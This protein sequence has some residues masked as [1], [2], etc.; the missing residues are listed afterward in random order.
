MRFGNRVLLIGVG[1]AVVY[2]FVEAFVDALVGEGSV[3]ERLLPRDTN[4][5]WMRL[6]TVVL[7]LGFAFYVRRTVHWRAQTAERLR[8]LE[9]AVQNA[10]DLVLITNARIDPPGPEIVYVNR[11]FCEQ[12]GYTTDELLGRTPRILQGLHSDRRVLDQIRNTLEREEDFL[13]GVTNYRKDGSE[14]QMEWRISPVRDSAGELTHWISIQRDRTEAKRAEE[15]LREIREAERRRIAR[16]LHDDVM[17]DLID[18]LYS[19]QVTRRKLKNDGVDVP[20]LE[21]EVETLRE[22]IAGLR[23]A[24]NDLRRGDAAE[25]PF[26]HL[27]RSLIEAT[28]QKAPNL[29]VVLSVDEAFAGGLTGPKALELLRL[30]QEALVNVRRHSGARR[31]SVNLCTIGDTARVEV[32]DDGRGFD[33]ETSWGGVGLSSMRERAVRLGGTFEVR[34]EPGEGTTVAAGVPVHKL[35]TTARGLSLSATREEVEDGT[36]G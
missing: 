9:F 24:I 17:Q 11:A 28:R 32:S 5:L 31:A 22:A 21:D 8:V 14:F 27:L 35:A 15:A 34:G 25:Q 23:G 10:N 30:V 26:G 13:G 2:W 29:E 16:D 20:E 4:E 33:M 7:V 36:R 19:M 6:V 18:A 3:Q 1:L 12:S